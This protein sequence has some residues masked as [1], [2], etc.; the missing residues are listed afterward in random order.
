[1]RPALGLTSWA[2]TAASWPFLA[3]PRAEK[4]STQVVLVAR[5]GEA[6]RHLSPF[7]NDPSRVPAAMPRAA[8]ASLAGFDGLGGARRRGGH[9]RSRG[10][11]LRGG[12]DL[13]KG[14]LGRGGGSLA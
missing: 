6:V 13:G 4:S 2:A 8:V 7:R 12:A 11:G 10:A 9:R 5:R 1:M 14:A 3:S